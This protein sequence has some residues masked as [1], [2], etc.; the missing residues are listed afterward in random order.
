[1]SHAA[2]RLAWGEKAAFGRFFHFSYAEIRMRTVVYIDGHNLFYSLLKKTPFKWLDL[3][4]LGSRVI[5]PIEPASEIA[6]TKYF[7]ASIL[8]SLADDPGA[9]R[10]RLTKYICNYLIIKD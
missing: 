3:N 7:T 1:L 8:G 2:P 10:W 9:E 5:R 4:R 6:R